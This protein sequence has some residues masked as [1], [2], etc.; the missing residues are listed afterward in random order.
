MR[1]RS[2]LGILLVLLALGS[3]KLQSQAP[4]SENNPINPNVDESGFLPWM[5]GDL[6]KVEMKKLLDGGFYA[7]KI[8][9]RKPY[10]RR[11]KFEYRAKLEKIPRHP[12]SFYYGFGMEKFQYDD[13][14]EKM[15]GKGMKEI[16]LNFFD[17]GR[18]PRF[19]TCWIKPD[20]E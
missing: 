2:V 15:L 12:W 11:P 8:E 9:G 3:I 5:E 14:R 20:T 6:L 17:D 13:F 10:G 18:R 4:N 16:D 1:I 19:Q 7:L